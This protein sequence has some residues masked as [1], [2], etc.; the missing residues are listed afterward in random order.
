MAAIDLYPHSKIYVAI[1]N[2]SRLWC[3]ITSL[4]WGTLD[5]GNI[6]LFPTWRGLFI[7]SIFHDYP[8]SHSISRDTSVHTFRHGYVRIWNCPRRSHV[9]FSRWRQSRIVAELADYLYCRGETID[10]L[11]NNW[12]HILRAL[13]TNGLRLSSAKTTICSRTATILC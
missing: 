10:D 7:K 11:L 1:T 8:W 3:L 5:Y 6:S 12:S 13:E 4:S 9:S 2:L